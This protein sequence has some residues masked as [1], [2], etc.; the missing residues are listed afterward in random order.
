MSINSIDMSSMLMGRSKLIIEG[1]AKLASRAKFDDFFVGSI[2]CKVTYPLGH[3][4]FAKNRIQRKKHKFG[5]EWSFAI[6]SIAILSKQ[7]RG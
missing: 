5:A 4:H 1:I 7:D 6:P 3:R 2:F